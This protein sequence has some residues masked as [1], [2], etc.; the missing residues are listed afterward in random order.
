MSVRLPDANIDR[1]GDQGVRF[2]ITGGTKAADTTAVVG[3]WIKALIG[4]NPFDNSYSRQLLTRASGGTGGNDGSITINQAGDTITARWKN[5]GNDILLPLSLSGLT[6]GNTYLALLIVNPTNV[7][8]VAC[9]PGQSPLVETVANTTMYSTA[10]TS[11][12]FI[13]GFGGAGTSNSRLF[14]G[15]LEELFYLNGEFPEAANVPDNTLI[16]AI[17]DGSQDLDTLDVELTGGVKRFRFRLLSQTDLADDY[18]LITDLV[19]S[20]ISAPDGKLLL[21]SGPLRPVALMPNMSR[22]CISQAVFGTTGD[23]ATAFATVYT[24]GGTYTGSPSAIQARLLNE[25]GAEVVGWTVVDPDPI[26]GFWSPGQITNVP[27]TT[28]F[29][30]CEFRAVDGVGSQ[31][32]ESVFSYGLRGAGFRVL[33]QA[34]SQLMYL[35]ENGGGIALPAGMRL[36]VTKASSSGVRSTMLSTSTDNDR[37]A[38]RGMRQAAIE[39]NTLYPG[40]PIEFDTVGQSG[41][42]LQEF[43][44]GGAHAGRWSALRDYQGIVQPFYMLFM[45]HSEATTSYYNKVATVVSFYESEYASGIANLHVPVPRYYNSGSDEL[46]GGNANAVYMSRNGARQ[47][48][49]DN[50]VRNKWMGSWST[51][52][53]GE[54]LAASDPHP[55]NDDEGQGRSGGMLG[56]A[57]MSACR[58]VVYEPFGFIEAKASG[59]TAIILRLG[60]INPPVSVAKIQFGTLTPIGQGQQS[61]N[62]VDG[63][64]TVG[65]GE[66]TVASGKIDVSVMPSPGSYYV[67]GNR[68]DVVA[69]ARTVSNISEVVPLWTDTT[70]LHPANTKIL[71]APGIYDITDQFIG[72][73]NRLLN[74]WEWTSIDNN[75]RA[76][77]TTTSTSQSG[78]LYAS[79]NPNGFT[80]RR[81]NFYRAQNP[82][83]IPWGTLPYDLFKVEGGALNVLIDDCEFYSDFIPAGEGGKLTTKVAGVSFDPGSSV[84]LSNCRIHHVCTGM[85]LEGEAQV[86]NN[87]IEEIYS[88]FIELRAGCSGTIRNNSMLGMIGDGTFFHGDMFQLQVPPNDPATGPLLI[89]GNVW[90]PGEVWTKAGGQIQV[91]ERKSQVPVS[92]AGPTVLDDVALYHGTR[93]NCQV[94]IA[95]GT[96]TLAL[97]RAADYPNM[98]LCLYQAGDGTVT[99]TK[100]AGDTVEDLLTMTSSNSSL[101]FVSDGVSHWRKIRPGYRPF[102]QERDYDVTMGEY[103][104][105]LAIFSD[106]STEN[107]T[108]TLPSSND[109]YNVSV[110]KDST[111]AFTTTVHVPSG[112]TAVLRGQTLTGPH[113]FVIK[114]C[115][116]TI[117]F[118][119]LEGTTE[120]LVTEETTTAQ[121]VFSNGPTAGYDD[122]T[123]RYN[124][125]FPNSPNGVRIAG[126]NGLTPGVVRTSKVYNNTILRATPPDI[127]G[128]G[129]I[130]AADT[131]NDGVVGNIHVYDGQDTFR[132]ALTGSIVPIDVDLGADIRELENQSFGWSDPED[133]SALNVFLRDNTPQSLRPTTRAQAIQ[134]ALVK[135]GSPLIIDESSHSF[136]G[137]TGTTLEN[138]PYNWVTGQPN[139][140]TKLPVLTNSSPADGASGV[141]TDAVITLTFDE[142]MSFGTGNISLR[143]VGGAE[144]EAFDVTSSVQLEIVANTVRITPSSALPLNTDVCIRVDSTALVGYFNNFAGITDDSLN[145]T[146]VTANPTVY[147][148]DNF[149]EVTDTPLASHTPDI[150]LSGNGWSALRQGA[151]PIVFG[152][153]SHLRWTTASGGGVEDSYTID[154]AANVRIES[155]ITG[156]STNNRGGFVFRGIDENNYFL[157]MF[158][159]GD[160]DEGTILSKR[161][162]GFTTTVAQITGNDVDGDPN[163]IQTG[164]VLDVVIAIAGNNIDVYFRDKL[165]MQVTDSDLSTAIKVGA[166]IRNTSVRFN[167]FRVEE[168]VN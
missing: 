127:N 3:F 108:H 63:T 81:V 6:P 51:I 11:T 153:L 2:V 89:E 85:R 80:F 95:G 60:P 62:A 82:V 158:R 17:A 15:A 154:A 135:A 72:Q 96:M 59:S 147:V 64:Y 8:L 99:V 133:I 79:P 103:E 47:Y 101:S 28:S 25:A 49:I 22:D 68:V 151:T 142:L 93:I 39:I 120:W 65:D 148:L 78:G 167:Y 137:A 116:E 136:I 57:L 138:G 84:T 32:G 38:V 100:D 50:P 58:A 7:H 66:F 90:A 19:P 36:V 144:I 83:G 140:N 165:K 1:A 130:S 119:R 45:G 123:I 146:T 112:Y 143:E 124:I 125:L 37:G 162:A 160:P 139:T 69:N 16:A 70:D 13:S 159:A 87:V 54:P 31:I 114:R 53:T 129:V 73:N 157:L 141:F 156:F 163:Y 5:G 105:D 92:V 109:R 86:I 132:N 55:S 29:L 131:W 61:I 149:D 150:D 30:R 23:V 9:E 46:A 4:N 40:V 35:W 24:E 48:C 44:T 118:E 117:S 161:L 126:D 115:S 52:K 27:I 12:A 111:S 20:N 134:A 102:T 97:P 91:T 43:Y 104:K 67:D 33:T 10:M 107:L 18:S 42:G 128:D 41:T 106:D 155:Q 21:T 110:K 88:D 34:Q 76:V 56:W 94:A 77:F 145:F 26:E 14:Y 75:N 98:T 121:G 71:L 74:D 152:G 166:A 113:D 164:E 122:I 168:I